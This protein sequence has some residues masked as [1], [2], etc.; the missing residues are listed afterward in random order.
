MTKPFA[1][2]RV[3]DFTQ[4]FAG[5]FGTF[6]LALLGA[7]V[8]K[9][10]RPGGEEMRNGPL[11]KEWSDRG[12]AM[13]GNGVIVNPTKNLKTLLKMSNIVIVMSKTFEN[14]IETH[15]NSFAGMLGPQSLISISGL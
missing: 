7:D 14:N 6:Q 15:R 2:V 13:C 5:P 11:S 8:I 1:G 9:V 3:L 4:V 12:M 10:E